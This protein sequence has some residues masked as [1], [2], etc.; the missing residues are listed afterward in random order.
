MFF[1]ATGPL[2][3]HFHGNQS[4]AKKPCGFLV[5]QSSSEV[6]AAVD[7]HDNPLPF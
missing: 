6:K 4:Q 1:M 5:F 3:A 7:S 2:L